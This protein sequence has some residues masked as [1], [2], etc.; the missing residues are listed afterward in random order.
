MM[1]SRV[2]LGVHSPADIVAGGSIGVLLLSAY[3]RVDDHLD[4]Y[5]GYGANGTLLKQWQL[6]TQQ[7]TLAE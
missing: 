4:H 3:L 5:I 1:F 6:L 2:Y 7:P